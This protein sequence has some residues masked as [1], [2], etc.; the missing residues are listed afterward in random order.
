MLGLPLLLMWTIPSSAADDPRAAREAQAIDGGADGVTHHTQQAD[1]QRLLPL[2]MAKQSVHA[3]VWNQLCDDRP[4]NLR[5]GGLFDAQ[6]KPKPA[7]EAIKQFRKEH[8]T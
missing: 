1:V 7:L 2:M 5:N 3:V 8:L 6:G 4:H